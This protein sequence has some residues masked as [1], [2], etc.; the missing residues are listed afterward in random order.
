LDILQG[1]TRIFNIDKPCFHFRPQAGKVLK[2]KGDKN[3][4]EIHRGLA[5]ASVTDM[6]TFSA[7]GMMCPPMLIYPYKTIPLEITKRVPDNWRVEHSPA[8]WMTAEVFR[9]I[10]EMF[11]LHILETL[12]SSFLLT[13]LLMDTAPI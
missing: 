5:K 1:P 8:G 4:Y 6:L 10:L 3:A 7:S 2:C 12:M 13:F 11:S 9:N